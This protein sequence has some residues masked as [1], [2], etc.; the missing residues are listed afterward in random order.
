MMIGLAGGYCAGK[1]RVAS[2]LEARGWACID[3]DRL[4][5][6]AIDL[7]RDAIAARFGPGV[8]AP[9]G[10]VDRR[11]VA[12]LIFADPLAL[13]DQEAIVHPVAI[14]LL[15]G[16]IAE[17]EDRARAAGGEARIC[18]NAALLHR[19]GIIASFDAIIEV[20]APLPA[21]VLRG[22]RRDKASPAAALARIRAQRR[23]GAELR[24]A[25]RAEGKAVIV[26]RNPGGPFSLERGLD[27]ALEKVEAALRR[28]ASAG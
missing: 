25:A 15:E 1:N 23:F 8:L 24:A 10:S 4:G 22:M 5:H 28:R 2:M 18:I 13:A 19:S 14:R 16:R 21:R 7:A 9:D 20:R 26:L 17:E 27:R 6:E 11:A 12:R 3:V